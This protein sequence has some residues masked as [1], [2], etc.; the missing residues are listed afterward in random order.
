VKDLTILIDGM[1]TAR[2]EV[3]PAI[4]EAGRSIWE[5]AEGFDANEIEGVGESVI[6]EL[7]KLRKKVQIEGSADAICEADED[8]FIIVGSQRE[9][10]RSVSVPIDGLLVDEDSGEASITGED[11]SGE[12]QS[13]RD[14]VES[15]SDQEYV[16]EGESSVDSQII[17]QEN[18][19]REGELDNV[20]IVAESPMR[21]GEAGVENL[22]A[23]TEDLKAFWD[24]LISAPAPPAPVDP[25]ALLMQETVEQ[26]LRKQELGKIPSI[27]RRVAEPSQTDD[28]W[29]SLQSELPKRSPDRR[30]RKKPT[31]APQCPPFALL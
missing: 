22:S 14:E 19:A 13:D 5:R 27:R 17:D 6:G 3:G 7:K 4:S 12:V 30:S 1:A 29:S 20:G 25:L 18:N 10:V 15:A 9:Q 8:D 11:E 23:S 28:A 31:T 24:G 26:E 2:M 16:I 21:E